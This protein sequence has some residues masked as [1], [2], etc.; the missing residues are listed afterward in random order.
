MQLVVVVLHSASVQKQTKTNN[1]KQIE[2]MFCFH[3]IWSEITTGQQNDFFILIFWCYLFSFDYELLCLS[4]YLFFCHDS[5]QSI[6]FEEYKRII[7][8]YFR[9]F[10]CNTINYKIIG[11]S[12]FKFL[13]HRISIF[14]LLA[15]FKIGN[16]IGERFFGF[17]GIISMEFGPFNGKHVYF[18]NKNWVQH[19]DYDFI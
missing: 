12:L 7:S 15:S 8:S 9:P 11:P 4:F 13:E 3:W 1:N 5:S 19:S 18:E 6:Y 16:W 10:H 2:F 14:D 17:F